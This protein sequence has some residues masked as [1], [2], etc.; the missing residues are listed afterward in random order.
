MNQHV[1]K[2]RCLGGYIEATDGDRHYISA[3]RVAKLYGIRPEECIFVNVDTPDTNLRS[4]S[5]EFINSLIDL[6]P[7]DSGI[8]ELF[9]RGDRVKFV[10]CPAHILGNDHICPIGKIVR[11]GQVKDDMITTESDFPPL[12]GYCLDKEYFERVK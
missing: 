7:Q 8:Y 1:K 6:W 12:N 4:Y 10:A 11:I 2:Y 3:S 5:A 9:S